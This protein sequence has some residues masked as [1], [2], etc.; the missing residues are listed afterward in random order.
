MVG[1]GWVEKVQADLKAEL[2]LLGETDAQVKLE[3]HKAAFDKLLKEFRSLKPLLVQIKNAYDKA[4]TESQTTAAEVGPLRSLVTTVAE[5]CERKILQLQQS[6]RDELNAMKDH[7]EQLNQTIKDKINENQDQHAQIV[8]LTQE[9]GE[10]YRKYR[11]ERCARRLLISDSND[12]KLSLKQDD[13]VSDHEDPVHMKLALDQSRK[14]LTKAQKSITKMEIEYAEVVPKKAFDDLTESFEKS[15]TIRKQA[16]EELEQIRKEHSILKETYA[17]VSSERDAAVKIKDDLGRSGTPRP[18]WEN[19]AISLKCATYSSTD[20]SSRDK[21]QNIVKQLNEV[22]TASGPNYITTHPPEPLPE[23]YP[24]YLRSESGI[25]RNRKLTPEE[26]AS[27]IK[28]IWKSRLSTSRQENLGDFLV[29]ELGRRFNEARDEYLYSLHH[30]LVSYKSEHEHF[31]RFM[32]Y[33]NGE[34]NEIE[35]VRIVSQTSDL[36]AAMQEHDKGKTGLITSDQFMQ[37]VT[38]ALPLKS[39]GAMNAVKTNFANESDVKYN[40]LFDEDPTGAPSGLVKLLQLQDHEEKQE[41]VELIKTQLANVGNVTKADAKV[42]F[43]SIDPGIN[44]EI[45]N[46]YLDYGLRGEESVSLTQYIE[47]ITKSPVYRV[48]PAPAN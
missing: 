28:E 24:D 35:Y 34:R 32:E 26:T 15:E 44:I 19:I 29:S 17:Q 21:V 27:L 30:A 2:T 16:Q 36:L 33:L 40:S 41:Y 47:N 31:N 43:M 18:E 37:A 20:L 12:R 3:P 48:S 5:D 8:R 10:L 25:V 6:E 45:I 23:K 22:K 1:V 42:A 4:L 38:K 46:E 14:D 7:A 39:P 11:D 13:D 9:V